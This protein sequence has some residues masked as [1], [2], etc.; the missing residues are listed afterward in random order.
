MELIIIIGGLYALYLV[1]MA[2]AT[3][4]DYRKSRRN[5]K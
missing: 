4:M 5:R 3:D 1:G 2:I